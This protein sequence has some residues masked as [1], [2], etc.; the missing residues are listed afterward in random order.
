M[1]AFR[2]DH[3][4]CFPAAKQSFAFG[5]LLR[6]DRLPL[7]IQWSRPN[8]PVRIAFTA[9]NPAKWMIHC[10]IVEHQ[11]IGMMGWFRGS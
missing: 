1:K 4:T 7:T 10:H 6:T 11:E 3:T 5:L 8:E 2:P 9:D